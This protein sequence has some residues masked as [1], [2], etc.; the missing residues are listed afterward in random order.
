MGF[1]ILIVDDSKT[2]REV[3]KKILRLGKVP[4]SGIFEATHGGEAMDIMDQ[5]WID[6]VMADIN[7]PVMNGVQ[8]VEA[9]LQH[10]LINTIPVIIVS[11]E[12]STTR[13]ENLERKGISAFIH[14]PFTPKY[15]A[16]IV[17]RT[18]E[19]ASTKENREKQ[20]SVG[21]RKYT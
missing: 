20:P 1:N 16:G 3:I 17:H 21:L 11:T 5:E 14:K 13:I 7:M 9:M 2:T 4:C 12:G 10:D 8:L 19:S 15:L 6:L 18:I